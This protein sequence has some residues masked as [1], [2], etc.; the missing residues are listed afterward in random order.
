MNGPDSQEPSRPGAEA[1][2]VRGETPVPA[3]R[4][5][6][7]RFPAARRSRDRRTPR[8]TPARFTSPFSTRE[9]P[10]YPPG[11]EVQVDPAA[12]EPGVAAEVAAPSEIGVALPLEAS[13]ER[14]IERVPSPPG[15]DH[16]P[17]GH[18]GFRV[19]TRDPKPEAGREISGEGD[20]AMAEP[21]L[22]SR[23]RA[24]PRE[25]VVEG[26]PGDPQSRAAAG[27]R[28]RP[29]PPSDGPSPVGSAPGRDAR[30][31]PSPRGSRAR[32]C[33]SAERNSPQTLSRGNSSFSTSRTAWP[34][35]DSAVAA[36]EPAGPAP[37]TTASKEVAVI[38]P[39]G[40][41]AAGKG[42]SFVT[43]APRNGARSESPDFFRR[44][45]L[46]DG[47][48]AVFH[49]DPAAEEQPSGEPDEDQ[50][51][52]V[53]PQVEQRKPDPRHAGE[54]GDQPFVVAGGEV[55]KQ[56]G[57]DDPVH[58]AVGK[59][60]SEGVGARGRRARPPHHAASRGEVAP[61]E[62][63]RD[64]LRRKLGLLERF[65]ES[66]RDVAGPAPTSSTTR[67]R[68]GARREL[69]RMNRSN[70]RLPPQVRLT[71]QRSRR[72]RSI[73]TEDRVGSSRSSSEGVR[74]GTS[75]E[76]MSFPAG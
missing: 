6:H 35:S 59:R 43:C 48:F 36:A 16:G 9:S 3:P 69:S 68:R 76:T 51:E 42:K 25:E 53:P 73:S 49:R 11:K 27:R 17:R 38:P 23:L 29:R 50:R 2:E 72:E 71:S 62:I 19:G 14:A 20:H 63:A 26:A 47:R 31:R 15:A 75:S 8:S 44:V 21:D 32:V 13:L 54:P 5:A 45:R 46:P 60:E 33:A 64:D 39:G 34:R 70:A 1:I 28:A 10:Q 52:E 55:V 18:L 12:K 24:A 74:G 40:R 37:T 22:R 61:L 56:E 7:D 66:S 57:R 4:P 65:R 41:P 67:R 30:P 58:R